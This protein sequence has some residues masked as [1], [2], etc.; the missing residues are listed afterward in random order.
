MNKKKDKSIIGVSLTNANWE[1]QEALDTI[2]LTED[3]RDQLKSPFED[4]VKIIEDNLL[5]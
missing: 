3:E 5:N 1:F 2:R 4:L